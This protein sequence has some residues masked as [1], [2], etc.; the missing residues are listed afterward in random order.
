[1]TSL[2]KYRSQ[3]L[4]HLNINKLHPRPIY[5]SI[6]SPSQ[7]G[8]IYAPRR[9][10][11]RAPGPRATRRGPYRHTRPRALWKGPQPGGPLP[12]QHSARTKKRQIRSW[13][14][15]TVTIIGTE[16]PDDGTLGPILADTGTEG[17]DGGTSAPKAAKKSV[18]GRKTERAPI[19]IRRSEVYFR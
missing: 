12:F 2:Q 1:M 18:P 7:A 3:S 17:P 16:G 10:S 4:K 13:R 15:A 8:A 11:N 9:L 14:S 19:R 6:L 5:I